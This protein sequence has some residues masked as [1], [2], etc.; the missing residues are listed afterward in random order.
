MSCRVLC[1]R[2]EPCRDAPSRDGALL[3]SSAHPCAALVR[4][5]LEV[6]WLARCSQSIF[7]DRTSFFTL[8]RI[9]RQAKL[10]LANPVSSPPPAEKG[11]TSDLF[12]WASL[13][14]THTVTETHTQLTL[15]HRETLHTSGK[16]AKC[17]LF[18]L[19]DIPLVCVDIFNV[20]RV[21]PRP[22]LDS[23]LPRTVELV[24]R[25]GASATSRNLPRSPISGCR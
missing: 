15:T 17:P 4:E 19:S 21:A 6:P 22:T 13:C 24:S 5:R 9:E 3:A 2:G 11:K 8:L 7:N 16:I 20:W 23:A 1:A 10:H 12:L 25:C 14:R 18:I